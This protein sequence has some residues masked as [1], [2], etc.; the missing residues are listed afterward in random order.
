M[1]GGQ[2]PQLKLS[3]LAIMR[4]ALPS[5]VWE[6]GALLHTYSAV[7]TVCTQGRIFKLLTPQMFAVQAAMLVL[8]VT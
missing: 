5:G 3:E 2:S 4:P 6:D 7:P 8:A 1:R